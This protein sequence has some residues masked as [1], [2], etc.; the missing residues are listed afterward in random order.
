MYLER[1]LVSII[2]S[3][4]KNLEIICVND[5]STDHSIDILHKY[6]GIDKRVI[7]I[8]KEN[9]DLSS[10]RNAGLDIAAGDY[11]S[12]V[13]SDD[14]IHPQFFEILVYY[15]EKTWAQIAA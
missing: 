8:E 14:W 13:A 11:I 9:G 1:C 4:Y 15:L 6:K 12:F 7:I 5:G 2:N 10:A 3:T